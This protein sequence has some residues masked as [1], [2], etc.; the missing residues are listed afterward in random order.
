MRAARFRRRV[1][2]GGGPVSLQG[3]RIPKG[4]FFFMS[5]FFVKHTVNHS[6]VPLFL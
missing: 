3:Y 5:S 6:V 2:F 1:I 4:G